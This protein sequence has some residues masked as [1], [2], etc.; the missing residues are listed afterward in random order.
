MEGSGGSSLFS[1][2]SCAGLR[3]GMTR[4][5]T[6][7][8]PFTV[9]RRL[10]PADV[11]DRRVARVGKHWDEALEGVLAGLGAW[12]EGIWTGD[13][14]REG[15]AR[16]DVDDDEDASVPSGVDKGERPDAER[17]SAAAARV[18]RIAEGCS[19]SAPGLWKRDPM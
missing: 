11:G 5:L 7:D 15:V 18:E 13:P 3:S 16:G 14:G 8:H 17:A 19:D 9:H 4:L 6:F 12:D 2:I 1:D 10:R